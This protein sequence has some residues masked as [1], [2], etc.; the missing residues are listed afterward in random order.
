MALYLPGPAISAL[1]GTLDGLNFTFSSKQLTVRRAARK[2]NMATPNTR[3]AQA[4]I[5]AAND[6]WR[7]QTSAT[8]AAWQTL[9]QTIKTT[10]SLTQQRS[11]SGHSLFVGHNALRYRCGI[12][13]DTTAPVRGV[14]P[15]AEVFTRVGTADPP[16][17][18]QIAPWGPTFS[19][20][21]CYAFLYGQNI[22]NASPRV[23]PPRL[24]LIGAYPIYFAVLTPIPAA[25]DWDRL[26]SLPQTNQRFYAEV[27]LCWD[28][29]LLSPAQG[30][31]FTVT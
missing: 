13:P 4:A 21:V 3:A 25:D 27:R 16:L 8:R 17:N 15:G 22:W 12:T 10:N 19:G 20:T 2:R 23:N 30:R 18:L 28:G 26:L 5:A 14:S 11:P 9:A 1:S 29:C 24:Q 31:F 6:L 7:A